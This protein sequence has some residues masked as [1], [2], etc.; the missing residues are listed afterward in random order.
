M[1]L[2]LLVGLCGATPGIAVGIVM[3]DDLCPISDTEPGNLLYWFRDGQHDT[4][5]CGHLIMWTN[6]ILD[7]NMPRLC[8]RRQNHKGPHVSGKFNWQ[9]KSTE[10]PPL[11]WWKNDE[12]TAIGIY[13]SHELC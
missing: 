5:M 11:V 13:A 9:L 2:S 10:T 1:Y 7:R 3:L 8:T 6:R 4:N 12:I